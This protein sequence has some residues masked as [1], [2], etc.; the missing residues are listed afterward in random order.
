MNKKQYKE[1]I[2]FCD[3]TSVGAHETLLLI[4]NLLNLEE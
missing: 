2:K 1:I 4:T 3:D